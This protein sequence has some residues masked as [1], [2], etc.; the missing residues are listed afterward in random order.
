MLAV[1]TGVPRFELAGI[2]QYVVQRVNHRLPCFL[3]DEDRQRYLQSLRQALLRFGGRLHAYA[4][5]KTTT[6]TW[7]ARQAREKGVRDNF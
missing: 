7:W 6:E 4:L 2:L 5:V 3:N 1:M